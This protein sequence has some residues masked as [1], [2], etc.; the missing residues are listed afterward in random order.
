VSKLKEAR[1]ARGLTQRELA[2]AAGVALGSIQKYESG[3]RDIN[4]AEA[5][6]IHKIALALDTD[7]ASI[8]N[9]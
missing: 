6:T 7:V 2:Q 5:L 3:E 1:L 9:A 4:K 8:I